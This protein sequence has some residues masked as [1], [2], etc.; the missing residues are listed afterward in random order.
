MTKSDQSLDAPL[1][2]YLTD[3]SKGNDSGNYRRNAERVLREWLSWTR[4]RRSADTFAALDVDD[5]EAYA[6]HLKRRT[7]D[8]DG[9]APAS[10]RKY[11]D[12]V[13]AYL[14]WCQR[15]EHLAD[16]P[17]AKRRATGALP[18]DDRR[19]EHGQQLWSPA[20][21]NAIVEYADER[22]REAIDETGSN[23]LAEARDRAFVATIA[24]SGVRGGEVLRDRNDARR[25]GVRWKDVDLDAGTMTVLE[26][27]SQEY[28][29]T[30]VPRQ[31]VSALDRWQTVF[32]PPSEEWPVFPTLHAP[33]LSS[34][35]ADGLDAAGY[36]DEEIEAM[37]DDATALELCYAEDIAPP[38][39]TTAG[40]RN[41][42]RRLSKAADVPGL[43]TEDGEY[44]ELH[45][46]RRGAGDTLVRR[47]GWE[48]AQKHLLHADPKTTMEAYSHISAEETADE[49]SEAFD[50]SDG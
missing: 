15:R 41:L 28:R 21:R 24:Y 46:G 17:A 10:A 5:L 4:D 19:S 42:M 13:R 9:L 1:A 45:G 37:R 23:A 36:T 31:A 22:A 32:D 35:V 50:E 6:R 29:Q 14:S 44:L 8:A 47:K 34:A 30:G 33:S 40:G 12:Y 20:Q 48:Q 25:E 18:D 26:K 49:A 11:F 39:L 3:K 7:N 43:D 38:A 27:G 16:N 2:D